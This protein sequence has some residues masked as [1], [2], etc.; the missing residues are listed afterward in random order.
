LIHIVEEVT[1]TQRNQDGKRR[2]AVT[3]RGGGSRY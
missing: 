3:D 1:K 2:A